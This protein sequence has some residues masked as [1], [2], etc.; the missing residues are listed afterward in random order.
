MP[1]SIGYFIQQ[2]PR[3]TSPRTKIFCFSTHSPEMLNWSPPSFGEIKGCKGRIFELFEEELFERIGLFTLLWY[4][5]IAIMLTSILL[6]YWAMDSQFSIIFTVWDFS[7]KINA[8]VPAN[9]WT[10]F[11]FF[12]V[13]NPSKELSRIFMISLS[14]KCAWSSSLRCNSSETVLG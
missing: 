3:E 13:S 6:P 4:P 8:F 11:E 14:E 7:S 1:I 2:S 12:N 9:K 10:M 5:L